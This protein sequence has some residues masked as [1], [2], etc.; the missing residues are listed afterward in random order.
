MPWWAPISNYCV[1]HCVIKT[2]ILPEYC[3]GGQMETTLME[4]FLNVELAMLCAESAYCLL[5]WTLQVRGQPSFFFGPAKNLW[6]GTNS[7]LPVEDR[8]WKLARESI[9]LTD[10]SNHVYNSSHNYLSLLLQ[11][12][13][14][15]NR[16]VNGHR[17]HKYCH[18]ITG[19]DYFKL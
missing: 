3:Q 8:D 2:Q 7:Y 11:Q 12:L 14:V 15:V 6:S 4:G 10:N 5:S 13:E 17:L 18:Y 19:H 9:G 1:N 16:D